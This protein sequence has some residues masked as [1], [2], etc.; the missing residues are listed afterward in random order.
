MRTGTL[1]AVSVA[2]EN[3]K[4][5]GMDKTTALTCKTCKTVD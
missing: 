3:L 1:G 5:S 4:T 2:K